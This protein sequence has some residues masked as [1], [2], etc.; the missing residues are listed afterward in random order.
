MHEYVH[1]NQ[2]F[3]TGGLC[4]GKKCYLALHCDKKH[5]FTVMYT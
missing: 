1:N 2:I 5:N 4:A 3:S